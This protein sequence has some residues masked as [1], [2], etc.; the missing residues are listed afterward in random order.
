M[1]ALDDTVIKNILFFWN[2]NYGMCFSVSLWYM[3]NWQVRCFCWTV[4]RNF[5]FELTN[6]IG[7]MYLFLKQLLFILLCFTYILARSER[8]HPMSRNF[9]THEVS[10]KSKFMPIRNWLGGFSY[11]IHYLNLQILC[12]TNGCKTRQAKIIFQWTKWKWN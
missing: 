2:Y 1:F 11:T 4:N 9:C 8:H 3:F 5:G 7:Y 6:W 12:Q 10:V